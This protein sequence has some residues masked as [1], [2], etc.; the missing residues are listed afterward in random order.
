METIECHNVFYLHSNDI[1]CC[2]CECVCECMCVCVCVC[3][4]VRVFVCACV[5]GSKDI[6]VSEHHKEGN[7]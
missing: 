6:N 5:C 1:I 2:V 3:M 4:C 7:G